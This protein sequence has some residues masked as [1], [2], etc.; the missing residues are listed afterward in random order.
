MQAFL[1]VPRKLSWYDAA[2]IVL[3]VNL[4]VL[5]VTLNGDTLYDLPVAANADVF[6]LYFST[7]AV[8]LTAEGAYFVSVLYDNVWRAAI[9]LQVVPQPTPDAQYRVAGTLTV[10][11][12]VAGAVDPN[13]RIYARVLSPDATVFTALTEA[14]YDYARGLY[15]APVAAEDLNT[16]GAYTVVWYKSLFNDPNWSTPAHFAAAELFVCDLPDLETVWLN[17]TSPAPNATAHADVIVVASTVRNGVLAAKAQGLTG[18]DGFCVLQLPP[19]HYVLSLV[20]SQRTFS[21]NN[22]EVEVVST[23]LETWTNQFPLVTACYY[24][25]LTSR[26][27]SPPLC[28]FTLQLFDVFGTP[29]AHADVAVNVVSPRMSPVGIGITRAARKTDSNGFL[30]FNLL[31]GARVEV[32]IAT[33]GL[34]RIFTVPSDTGPYDL[35]TTLS[36]AVDLFDAI[37]PVVPAAPRRTL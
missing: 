10:T 5:R 7:T 16:R 1:G 31:Q 30:E 12:A 27:A 13:T 35:L 20:D 3:D 23:R 37:T 14:A 24:P 15:V 22:F 8:T 6:G 36:G 28:T 33:L 32:T 34:R 29:V 4:L 19:G 18:G 9:P 17:V 21:V 2:G 25:T 11:E 26:P